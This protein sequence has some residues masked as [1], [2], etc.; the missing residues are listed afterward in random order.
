MAAKHGAAK[1]F[2]CE[3][4]GLEFAY[5]QIM[6]LHVQTKHGTSK[7][8]VCNVCGKEFAYNCTMKVHIRAKHPEKS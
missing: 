3:V 1:E 2:R 4:C 7:K 5:K 8:F 6:K